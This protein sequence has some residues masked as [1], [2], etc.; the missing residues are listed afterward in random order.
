MG[1]CH[2]N[3]V[4]MRHLGR[5]G[6]LLAVSD[7]LLYTLVSTQTLVYAMLSEKAALAVWRWWLL[8]RANA[9]TASAAFFAAYRFLLSAFF[10]ALKLAKP[11]CCQSS[12]AS[13]CGLRV[14]TKPEIQIWLPT[15]TGRTLSGFSY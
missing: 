11:S 15:V 6:T 3:T 13:A 14:V 5:S 2:A 1:I 10:H 12:I 7:T 9:A 8:R 4:L